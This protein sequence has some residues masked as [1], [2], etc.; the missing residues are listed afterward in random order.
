MTQVPAQRSERIVRKEYHHG[1]TPAAWTG[2]I[3]AAVGFVL[4]AIASVIGPNWPM[5]WVGG[6]LVLLGMIVGYVMRRLGMGQG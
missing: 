3:V 6:A 2:S 5:I 1:M 4:A